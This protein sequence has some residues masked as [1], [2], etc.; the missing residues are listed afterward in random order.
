MRPASFFCAAAIA[1]CTS[2]SHVVSAGHGTYRVSATNDACDNCT[3]ALDLVKQ[4]ASEYCAKMS[5]TMVVEDQHEERYHLGER[6]TLTF[7]CE[8][9]H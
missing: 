3:P 2:T 6:I 1:G 5:K 4:E 9:S 7:T 8:P